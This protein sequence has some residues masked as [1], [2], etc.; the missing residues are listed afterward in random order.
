MRYFVVGPNGERYGPA[1]VAMLSQWVQEGR[2]LGHHLIEV[3]ATGQRIQ[4]AQI[5]GLVFTQPHQQPPQAWNQPFGATPPSPYQA[6]SS[7][8]GAYDSDIGQRDYNTALICGGVSIA[9]TLGI[10]FSFLLGAIILAAVGMRSAYKARAL[11]HHNANTAV[12]IVWLALI[13]AAAS[14]LGVLHRLPFFGF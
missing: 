1:D 13:L 3:E 10:P 9:F 6:P 8:F 7:G 5:P 4:A 12:S 14:Q 11:L 2:V